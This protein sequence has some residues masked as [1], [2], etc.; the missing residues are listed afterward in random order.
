M[1]KN[2]NPGPGMYKIKGFAD[3]VALRG[4]KINLTRIKLR[5]K[6]KD[7]EIDKERRAKLRE[8]W[9]REKKSQLKIS[10]K[11]YYNFKINKDEN[12]DEINNKDNNN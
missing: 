5:E 1:D 10:I 4:S 9:N 8:L 12:K 7:E 11:D 2:E 6:E 3:D